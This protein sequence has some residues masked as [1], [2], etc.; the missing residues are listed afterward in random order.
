LG[1]VAWRLSGF[2]FNMLW[3]VFWVALWFNW[4][5]AEQCR[6]FVPS[7]D[8]YLRISRKLYHDE[9]REY[10]CFYR[11]THEYWF[12]KILTVDEAVEIPYAEVIATDRP[13][14]HL[15]QYKQLEGMVPQFCVHYRG[16]DYLATYH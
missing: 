10:T 13:L 8:S 2:H 15:P 14:A 12:G 11:V 6:V 7:H 3:V 4:V 5:Q 9:F 16:Q 1:Y